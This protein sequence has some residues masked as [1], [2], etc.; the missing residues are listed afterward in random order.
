MLRFQQAEKRSQYEEECRK[1]AI[2]EEVQRK[3]LDQLSEEIEQKRKLIEWE[4]DT[5][6]GLL[7]FCMWSHV[8]VS[9]IYHRIDG[10]V[11]DCSNSSALAV[12]LLQSCT[13][14]TIC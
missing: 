3:Q 7:A 10:L 5:V 12:E 1:M 6:S 4:R 2:R 14:C 13:I 9:F 11:Q 8:R